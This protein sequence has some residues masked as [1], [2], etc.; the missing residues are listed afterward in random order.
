MQRRI[1]N[2]DNTGHM[3]LRKVGG[4]GDGQDWEHEMDVLPQRKPTV[5]RAGAAA[6]RKSIFDTGEDDGEARTHF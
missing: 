3:V 4:D 6:R 2:I 1:L 5:R